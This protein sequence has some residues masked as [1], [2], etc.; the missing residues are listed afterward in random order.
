[1]DGFVES[2]LLIA[3]T[4]LAG[5]LLIGTVGGAIYSRR[6]AARK[7][8]LRGIKSYNGVVRN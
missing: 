6:R 2:R 8:R 3:Y 7:R 4:L 5:I 1:M